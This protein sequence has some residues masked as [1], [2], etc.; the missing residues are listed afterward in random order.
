M[1][2]NAGDSL[3]THLIDCRREISKWKRRYRT[4]AQ[5]DIALLKNCLDKAHTDGY[6]THTIRD[7]RLQLSKAYANEKEFWR[8]KSRKTWLA[9]G[10]RNT[11]YFFA[12]TK[13]RMA[14]NR[15]YSIHDDD[16]TKHRGTNRIGEVAQDFFTKLFQSE[17]TPQNNHFHVLNGFQQRVI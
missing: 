14:R 13:T 17:L 5:E 16:G 6:T 15:M 11:K 7:L 3:Q 4:N 1:R 8:L 9:G 10:D 12:S 2:R